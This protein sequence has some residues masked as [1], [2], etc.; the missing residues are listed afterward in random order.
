M[1]Q[2]SADTVS[3]DGGG[4]GGGAG[5]RRRPAT[6]TTV[7]WFRLKLP[8][9]EN[10]VSCCTPAPSVTGSVTVVHVCHP[11]VFGTR[12]SAQTLLRLLNPTCSRPPVG[13]ATRSSR[14]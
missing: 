1:F 6:S 13:D 8:V 10:S 7:M 11:P 12:T 5:G 2:V 3:P 4:K 9:S 14:E